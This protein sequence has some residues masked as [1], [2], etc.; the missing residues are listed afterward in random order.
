MNLKQFL[1]SKLQNA[2][3]SEPCPR[4]RDVR[5]EVYVRRGH[6]VLTK[7]AGDTFPCLD[8]ANI[9]VVKEYRGHGYFTKFLSRAEKEASNR[10]WAIFV[11][12]ILEP[13]LAIF[14]KKRG[15]V[16]VYNQPNCLFNRGWVEDGSTTFN[17]I[18]CS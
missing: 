14:L 18:V 7:D 10:G 3:L 11:E 17:G 12:S 9:Q 4:G 8:L 15:Y 16:D 6:H 1:R 13:R 2:W 5:I